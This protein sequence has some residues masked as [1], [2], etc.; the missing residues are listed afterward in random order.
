MRTYTTISGDMWDLIAFN[1]L[2]TANATGQL[3]MMNH[4]Y[5]DYFIFPAGIV[6]NLPEEDEIEEPVN[7]LL[8]PWKR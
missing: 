1:Q 3:M 5:V 4:L 7:E 2:G 6:L 8:P